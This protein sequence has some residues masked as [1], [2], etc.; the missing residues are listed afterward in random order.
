MLDD[1]GLC[2]PLRAYCGNRWHTTL[3]IPIL[4]VATSLLLLT[5][6]F[7]LQHFGDRGLGG[8][9][10]GQSEVEDQGDIR[11]DAKDFLGR[12]GGFVVFAYRATRLVA[13]IALFG[14]QLYQFLKDTTVTEGGSVW[15]GLLRE[16]QYP[17]LAM[18]I[19]YVSN[20]D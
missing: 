16:D 4:F 12:H 1:C 13:C 19:T 2:G 15:G 3:L 14:I 11:P 10:L 7:A 9:Q 17:E 20:D 8:S 18:V 6:R 5:T